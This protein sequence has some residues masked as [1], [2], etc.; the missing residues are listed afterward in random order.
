MNVIYV[1]S[2]RKIIINVYTQ[3]NCNIQF[4]VLLYYL[5]LLGD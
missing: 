4:F 3:N 1:F 5:F 2:P